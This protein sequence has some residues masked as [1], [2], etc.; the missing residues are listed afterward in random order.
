MTQKP[1][2]EDGQS[3][4]AQVPG[5]PKLSAA[6]L[7]ELA[8]HNQAAPSKKLAKTG[9]KISDGATVEPKALEADEH[10]G[11]D[12]PGAAS[13]AT[14]DQLASPENDAAV[15][16]IVHTE[17]DQLLAQSDAAAQ[18]KT[19]VQRGFWRS[20]GH[21]FARWWGSPWARWITII[22]IVGTAITL[23]SIPTTRYAILNFLGVRASATVTVFDSDTRLPLKNIQVE[24]G[25]Q[26]GFTNSN[27]LAKVAHLRLGKQTVTI[28]RFGYKTV[29][30]NIVAGWGSNPL[31]PFYIVATGS[32]YTLKVTDYVSGMGIANVEADSGQ[33]SATSDKNGVITLTL[34][35]NV[36]QAD[37]TVQAANYRTEQLH[38][39]LLS[40]PAGLL[41]LVPSAKEI[42]AAKQNNIY[43]IVASDI[44][45]KNQSVILAGTGRENANIALAVNPAH[46]HAAVISTRDTIRDGDNYLLNTLSVVGLN[47]G[48]QTVVRAEQIKLIDWI[49]TRLVF[50]EAVAGVS[51][52]N[53]QRYK[54]I[55]YD[56]STNTQVQLANANQFNGIL[57]AQGQIYY[58][59]SSTDPTTHA[60]FWRVRP[61]GS[62]RQNLYNNEVWAVFRTDF[63]TITMQS[64]SGWLSYAINGNGNVQLASQPASIQNRFY[65]PNSSTQNI[66][67]NSQDSPASVN[68]YDSAT[69]NNK[70]LTSQTGLGTPV[71][72]LNDATA[73]YRVATAQETADYAVNTSNGHTKKIA[74]V[75]N[76]SGLTPAN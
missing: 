53:S 20:I 66:W 41:S 59:V 64:P 75:V 57:S 34:D 48:T 13:E 54:L 56:Y 18:P 60:A 49:G 8:T 15:D 45:G 36:T 72:W 47:G 14:S 27:G 24:A 3:E 33:A 61:D 23:G 31:Q 11:N 22:V 25:G 46:D 6:L 28:K 70:K 38:I 12:A 39:N 5:A 73:V 52:S 40:T 76:T 9:K 63:N 42:Y 55:A 32:Q 50:E 74:D 2:K 71:Y 26:S 21:F 37:V 62:S 43:N 58:A 1:K 65:L 29:S 17:S 44:D 7:A 4:N 19:P 30:Q 16:D 69:G 51:A 68:I 67:I 35:N 10:S